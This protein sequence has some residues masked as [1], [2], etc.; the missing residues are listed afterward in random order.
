M[1]EN[2]NASDSKILE[3]VIAMMILKRMLSSPTY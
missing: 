1:I 2:E 3:Y